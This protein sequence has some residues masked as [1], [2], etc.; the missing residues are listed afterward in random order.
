MSNEKIIFA[1]LGKKESGK[2][3]AA[4]FLKEKYGAEICSFARPLK[5]MVKDIF[6]LTDDQ[7]YGATKEVRDLRWNFTP[8]WI[9]QKIGNKARDYIDK[10]IWID[11]LVSNIEKSDNKIFVVEDCRYVNEVACVFSSPIESYIIKLEGPRE[12]TDNHASEAEVDQAPE[13]MI[14]TKIKNDYDQKFLDEV[15]LFV[16]S[17]LR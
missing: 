17:K 13:F 4:K 3:T 11:L 5:E 16:E 9:L 10:N 12:S 2:S 6:D 8:R 7:V 15:D 14:S 1:L